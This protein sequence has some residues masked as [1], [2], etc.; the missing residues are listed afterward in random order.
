MATT[1]V[2]RRALRRRRIIERPRL[3]ALLDGSDAVN[4]D[5][6]YSCAYVVLRTDQGSEGHGFTFTTGRGTEIVVESVK[7]LTSRIVGKT[8]P[9]R[10]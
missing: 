1:R 5:P 3:F 8:L 6:D 9:E 7:A 4:V 10:P 2:H